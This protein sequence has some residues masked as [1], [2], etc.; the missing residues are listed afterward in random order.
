MS[1]TELQ[2]FMKA[3]F[4]PKYTIN[5]DGGGSTS[6]FIR[7]KNVV[8]YPCEGVSGDTYKPYPGSFKERGLVTYF[9]IREK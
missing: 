8:N 7:G 9:A 1:Y 4:N 6:M 3:Y 2:N 5:M